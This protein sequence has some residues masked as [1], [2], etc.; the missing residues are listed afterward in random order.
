MAP[1]RMVGWGLVVAG[2][3][4][5]WRGWAMHRSLAG[6]LENLLGGGN[7]PWLWMAAGAAAL[8]VGLGLAARR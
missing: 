4:A 7:E 1:K 5:M 8:V 3:L 6:R 2:A